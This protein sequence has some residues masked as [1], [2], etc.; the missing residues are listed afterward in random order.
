MGPHLHKFRYIFKA[1]IVAIL[2]GATSCTLAH[3][4]K[5]SASFE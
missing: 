2:L 4:A 1:A 5:N 3:P